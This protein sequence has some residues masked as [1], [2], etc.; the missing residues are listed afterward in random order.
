VFANGAG[1]DR[2]EFIKCKYSW[3]AA[4]PALLRRHHVLRHRVRYR[5]RYTFLPFVK[6][7]W[8]RMI[9]TFLLHVSKHL[10]T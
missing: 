1:R 6:D 3:F 5:S 4:F 10:P 8:A 2:Q 9:M 7:W